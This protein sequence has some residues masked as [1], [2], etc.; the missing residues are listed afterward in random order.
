M[1]DKSKSSI[2]NASSYEEMGDFWDIHSL[3]DYDGQTYEV[4]MA[5]D[6]AA[7]RTQVG[8]DPDLL[9]EL[10]QIAT[11]RHISTQTLVNLWLSE[12]VRYL[13]T[14]MT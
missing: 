9:A 1:E 12:R 2:S 13:K 4:E 10:R 3:A 14:Q 11:Q 5:F 6:P 7:R 8:I